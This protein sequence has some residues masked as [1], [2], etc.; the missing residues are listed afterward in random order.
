MPRRKYF[1][2]AQLPLLADASA[3]LCQCGCQKP[4][5]LSADGKILKYATNDCR[6]P[7][8]T[9][10]PDAKRRARMVARVGVRYQP[11]VDDYSAEEI[12]RRLRAGDQRIRAQRRYD[13]WKRDREAGLA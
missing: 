12:E 4:R 11:E 2:A 10:L 9:R 7:K 3:P 6:K 13:N 8:R 5:R 1:R